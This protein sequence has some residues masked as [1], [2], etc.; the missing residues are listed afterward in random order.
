MQALRRAKAAQHRCQTGKL[1]A[2][3][4][5]RKQCGATESEDAVARD[6]R[7]AERQQWTD[8]LHRR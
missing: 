8:E 1:A 2:D 4:T 5:I 3:H 6:P 7:G